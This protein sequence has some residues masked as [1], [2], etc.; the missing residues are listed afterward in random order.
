LRQEA[1]TPG[2]VRC[3]WPWMP[4]LDELLQNFR[5]EPIPVWHENLV[6]SSDSPFRSDCPC[7][8]PGTLGVTRHRDTL[9]LQRLDRCISCG[10]H[11]VYQ[12]KAIANEPLPPLDLTSVV[13]EWR[14]LISTV[15]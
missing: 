8:R 3:K 15:K 13:A 10:Q 12:D 7:C 1:F 9:E 4:T 14:H 5:K 11:F 6:R 2:R